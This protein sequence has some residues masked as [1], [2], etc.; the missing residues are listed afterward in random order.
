MSRVVVACAFL[1]LA[2]GSALPIEATARWLAGSDAAPQD[3]ATGVAILKGALALQGVVLV[4]AARFAPRA[5]RFEPLISQGV[6][7]ARRESAST[8]WGIGGVLV[9]AT[10]L[11]MSSLGAGPS[12]EEIDLILHSARRPLGQ[13]VSLLGGRDQHGLYPAL[14]GISCAALGESAASARLPAALLGVA[15]I[16]ALHR[17]ALLVAGRREALFA[18]ALAT[19]SYQHVWFSQ[20][21]SAFTGLLCFTLLASASFV[22]MLAER[23]PRGI[24]RP[25]AY[26]AWMALAAWMHAGALCVAA[27]HGL[28]W[29]ALAWST[30]RRAVR[31]NRWQP[32][33][34][35]A[36]AVTLSLAAHALLLPQIFRAWIESPAASR[37]AASFDFARTLGELSRAVIGGP[38]VIGLGL[39]IALVGALGYLRKGPA[40]LA[41]MLAPVATTA[42]AV[43]ALRPE[44]WPRL[45]FSSAGF[46][47]LVAL[48]GC[49]EWVRV[50]SFGLLGGLA[51]TLATTL[52]ALACLMSA[53][54]LP[55]VWAPKQDF[56]GAQRFVEGMRVPGDAVV[57]IDRTVAPYRDYYTAR[58]TAVDNLADLR[59]VEA[60]HPRTWIVYTSPDRMQSEHPDVWERIARDYA[61]LQAFRGTLDGG[62]VFVASHPKPEE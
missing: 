12:F 50:F 24:A 33:V 15:S 42:I 60:A 31:W 37:T 48:R 41:T 55:G 26:G 2:A 9:L 6:S 30:R 29:L 49:T 62:D 4:L 14:A 36:F 27:A 13:V 20:S 57:T 16:L 3:L 53:A 32:A 7:P 11:R 38:A 35:F 17:F 19:V 51:R 40:V 18:A 54:T 10:A 1:L 47:A 59:R 45:F 5:G 28:V 25:L 39:A 34:G 56:E 44:R 8:L 21:A 61:A 58:W 22:R 23:E 52:L 43:L 46:A